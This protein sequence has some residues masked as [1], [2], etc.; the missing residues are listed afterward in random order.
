MRRLR[1]G[2]S[3]I[4]QLGIVRHCASLASSPMKF[5][6]LVLLV[7]GGLVVLSACGGS[8]TSGAGDALGENRIIA[9]DE[10]SGQAALEKKYADFGN[11]LETD[12]DGNMRI[13]KGVKRSSFE[14]KE[15]ARIGGAK[16]EYSFKRYKKK[17]WGR[18]KRYS[19]NEFSGKK[20]SR[21]QDAE[22]F[23]RKEAQGASQTAREAGSSYGRK[24]YTTDSA[25]EMNS[26]GYGNL[27]EA[28]S[29]FSGE[30]APE[31]LIMSQSEYEQ[32]SV[33]EVNRRLGR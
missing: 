3:E 16:K 17:E 4:W 5:L 15:V 27:A 32:L 11:V 9:L 26:D 19:A 23:L 25:R 29:Q 13:A 14:G 7:V 20:E 33:N 31:P 1:R 21:W 6:N 12:E 8:E 10:S 30:Q 22:W 2:W 24:S 18:D 28:Q